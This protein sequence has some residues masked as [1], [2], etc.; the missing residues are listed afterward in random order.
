MRI[1]IIYALSLTFLLLFLSNQLLSQNKFLKLTPE[2]SIHIISSEFQKLGHFEDINKKLRK[3]I[4]KNLEFPNKHRFQHLFQVCYDCEKIKFSVVSISKQ[5]IVLNYVR[6]GRGKYFQTSFVRFNER[7]IVS[8]IVFNSPLFQDIQ[9]LI[10]DFMR[11]PE[12]WKLI[13][14][15]H[16]KR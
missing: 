12:N 2:D 10:G 14:K 11:M 1:K 9:D 8:M 13:I 3:S 4:S 16:E 6:G 7:G 15:K 5:W